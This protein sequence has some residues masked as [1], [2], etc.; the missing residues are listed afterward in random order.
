MACA[1]CYDTQTTVVQGHVR[2]CPDCRPLPG[3]Q[4][5]GVLDQAYRT[6]EQV[7]GEALNALAAVHNDA[8]S[9][10]MRAVR[11]VHAL[12]GAGYVIGKAAKP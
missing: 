3:D 9:P 6:A 2:P 4:F 10:L 5:V 8:A 11:M 7:P 12:Y 1:T